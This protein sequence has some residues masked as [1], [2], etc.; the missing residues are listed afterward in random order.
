MK[1]LKND[2]G[3]WL[4]QTDHNWWMSRQNTMNTQKWRKMDKEKM[5][6]TKAEKL[7]NWEMEK[8]G[9]LMK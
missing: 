7:I 9:R 4:I 3:K 5:N 8:R 6:L 1:L 2:E